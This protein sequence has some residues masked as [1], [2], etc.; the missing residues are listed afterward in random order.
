V[1]GTTPSCTSVAF[2]TERSTDFLVR[3]D[4]V[5]TPKRRSR[6]TEAQRSVAGVASLI[7]CGEEKASLARL[8]V[9]L[10]VAR[11]ALEVVVA[12]GPTP[13]PALTT[14]LPDRATG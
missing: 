4:P 9:E 3:L 14:V 6:A 8:S 1:D 13:M 7:R 2:L 11:A 12:E 10:R 5:A